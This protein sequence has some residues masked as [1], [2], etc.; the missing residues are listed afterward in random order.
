MCEKG[1]VGGGWLPQFG[2][3]R[4]SARWE[5]VADA[6]ENRTGHSGSG[7]DRLQPPIDVQKLGFRLGSELSRPVSLEAPRHD[8]IPLGINDRCQVGDVVG[9]GQ[10]Q[11]FVGIDAEHF[12]SDRVG[13]GLGR[14]DADPQSCERTG[15]GCDGHKLHILGCPSGLL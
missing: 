3:Q 4:L 8:L 5:A 10:R 11:G 1:H 7:S 14:G 6:A 15:A 12:R 9:A 13:E 2:W